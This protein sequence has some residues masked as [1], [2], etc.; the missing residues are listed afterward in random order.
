MYS[1]DT[2]IVG[3]SLANAQSLALASRLAYTELPTVTGRGTDT[4]VLI[5]ELD[6]AIVIAFRGTTTLRDFVTDAQAWRENLADCQIHCGFLAAWKSVMDGIA[7]QLVTLPPK[8]LFIT[9]HSLGGALAVLCANV[10]AGR[11]HSVY[12][13]G[14]PRV[15]NAD[16]ANRSRALLS[17]RHFRIVNA[18]DIVPRLPGALIG[19]RHSGE[20]IFLDALGRL[21]QNAALWLMAVSDAFGLWEEW[22]QS[23]RIAL[24]ADHHI[25]RYII[26][27]SESSSSSSSSSLTLNPKLK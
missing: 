14:Q 2:T 18:N 25:D 3:F 8:P 12:T 15:G 10:L 27:L 21:E 20:Q 13:F 23:K 16:F 22:N 7:T 17:G 11:V 4:Q 24:L 5:T 6:N 9:G 19:Y 26:A 1:L